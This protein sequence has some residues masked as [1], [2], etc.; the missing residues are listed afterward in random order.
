M[1]LDPCEEYTRE[2][3]EEILSQPLETEEQIL[4]ALSSLPADDAR[5]II[6]NLLVA[7]NQ[8]IWAEACAE[9]AKEYAADVA[10]AADCAAAYAAH[11]ADAYAAY[12][13]YA[14][15]AYAEYANAAAAARAARAA[16]AAYAARAA[17]AAR[18]ARAAA[19]AADAATN[20][21]RNVW[22]VFQEIV[23]EAYALG[24]GD[25]E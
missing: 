2:R 21:E 19:Y 11:D 7:P 16:N 3:I 25:S 15:A 1:A 13:E 18:A 23:L 20:A 17:N 10:A 9:R 24:T 14:A 5:W 22:N 6:S 8:V 4:S 12:A